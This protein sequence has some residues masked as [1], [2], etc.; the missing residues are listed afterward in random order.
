MTSSPK[1]SA[2]SSKDVSADASDAEPALDDHH[3]QNNDDGDIDDDDAARH[4]GAASTPQ[5]LGELG[6][7]MTRTESLP[8]ETFSCSSNSSS[9][10]STPA[11]KRGGKGGRGGGGEEDEDFSPMIKVRHCC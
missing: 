7:A 5:M 6:P 2:P 3:H 8:T 9:G 10:S 1:R 4:D 11:K